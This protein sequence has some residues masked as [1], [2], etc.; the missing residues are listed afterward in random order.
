MLKKEASG[1]S[2]QT[3]SRD[4][5]DQNTSHDTADH[6]TSHGIIYIMYISY[7]A[8]A[9]YTYMHYDIINCV[10]IFINEVHCQ[11]SS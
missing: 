9:I 8:V 11:R 10:A 6:P 4:T 7:V 2:S 5:N 3:V 1:A